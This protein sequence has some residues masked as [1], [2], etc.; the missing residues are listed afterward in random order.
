MSADTALYLIYLVIT[1]VYHIILTLA[2]YQP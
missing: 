1:L 2:E